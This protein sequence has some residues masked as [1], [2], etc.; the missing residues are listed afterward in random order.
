MMESGRS[1]WR[2]EHDIIAVYAMGALVVTVT[3]IYFLQK[4]IRKNAKRNWGYGRSGKAGPISRG[5]YV[6]WGLEFLALG[7]FSAALS[8]KNPPW[9]RELSGVGVMACFVAFLATGI[10]DLAL[11]RRSERRRADDR[12]R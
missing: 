2:F 7:V 12:L 10:T 6:F 1:T 3:G 4:G 9:D 11:W 8:A 5:G